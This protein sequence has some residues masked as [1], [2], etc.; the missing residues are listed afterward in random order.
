M[1]GGR[2]TTPLFD[3]LRR[4]N[5][6]PTATPAPTRSA[7]P[8]V[9]VELKPQTDP[10]PLSPSHDLPPAP[11]QQTLAIQTNTIWFAAAA[12]LTALFVIFVVGYKLGQSA[13]S[14]RAEQELSGRFGDRPNLSEPVDQ[15]AI[16]PAPDRTP[17][18]VKAPQSRP[19]T[20]APVRPETDAGPGA[21]TGAVI[22]ATGVSADRREPGKNYLAMATLGL[23]ETKAAIQFMAAN[24]VEVIGV[25][26]DRGGVRANNAGPA[27]TYRLYAASGITSEQFRTKQTVRTNLE[28]EVARLG[29]IWQKQ[30]RGASN[31]A[32]TGWEKFQ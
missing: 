12:A 22:T 16:A 31:F 11:A 27:E 29:E 13:E 10:P 24:G 17:V 15:P 1:Q 25:P 9:R 23:A 32:K 14:R 5:A 3:L 30:H 2:Q 7:K 19:T 28:A 6:A 26:V 18:A 8:M 20:P 4:A 21:G